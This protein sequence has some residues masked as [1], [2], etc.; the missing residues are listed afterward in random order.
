MVKYC[1]CG[2]YTFQVWVTEKLINLR[3]HKCRNLYKIR[4]QGSKHG[5]G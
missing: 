5:K 2:N 4:K 3:C 1:K